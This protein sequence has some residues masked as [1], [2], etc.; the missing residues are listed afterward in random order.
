M[1]KALHYLILMAIKFLPPDEIIE[2]CVETSCSC[3]SLRSLHCHHIL[4]DYIRCEITIAGIL[5][6]SIVYSEN[7]KSFWKLDLFPS[8]GE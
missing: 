7:N 2:S 8:T 4:L 1:F 6:L 5:Y 3:T